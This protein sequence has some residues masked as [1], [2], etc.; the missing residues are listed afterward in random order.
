MQSLSRLWPLFREAIKAMRLS[1][2]GWPLARAAI[3]RYFAA[4]KTT[5]P[6]TIVSVG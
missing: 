1:L 6:P 5:R 4:L 2:F 3:N